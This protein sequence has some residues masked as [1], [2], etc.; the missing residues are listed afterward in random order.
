MV[1]QLI[2][3]RRKFEQADNYIFDADLDT[4][5]LTKNNKILFN[6]LFVEDSKYKLISSSPKVFAAIH[7]DDFTDNFYLSEVEM[8]AYISG[9]IESVNDNIQTALDKAIADGAEDDLNKAALD[10]ADVKLNLYRSFKS[11]YDKWI[12]SSENGQTSGYF[13]NNYGKDKDER[14]LYDH[15]KFVNRA[16]QEVGD[17]AAIDFTYLS[18]LANTKN[19]QGPT[20][21]LY[22]SLTELLG[23]NN[24]DFWPLP[25]DIDLTTQSMS[26]E[27]VKDIFRPLDFVGNIKASPMFLCVYVGGSSRT[28][29]DLNGKGNSCGDQKDDFQ[30][31]DDSFDLTD[32]T[33][34]PDEYLANEDN[35]LVIFKVRYGQ[36]AQNHFYGLQLDQAEFK[37]T[38]ES[39]QII[40]AMT[41][42][43][44]GS[45]PSQAGKGNG[46]YDVYLTRSYNCTVSSLGNMSIQPLMYFKL[47]NVPMFRGTYLITGVKHSVTP[48]NIKTEFTG[49]RQPRITVPVV[50]DA[51]SLLDLSLL[52]LESDS[53]GYSGPSTN[54]VNNGYNSDTSSDTVGAT[55]GA[56]REDMKVDKLAP[57]FDVSFKKIITNGTYAGIT[58]S[59][60]QDDW[61]SVTSNYIGRKETFTA[62]AANDEGT[63]RAGY[64][65]DKI[66]I[67]GSLQKVKA[68][69]VFTR[70]IAKNTLV[71][72]VKNTYAKQIEKDLGTSNWNKLNKFQKAALVSLGYN[73][74]AYY[75]SARKYGKQIKLAIQNNDF[76]EAAQGILNGPI[77]GA[78]SG[79]LKGLINRRI[80]EARLF[81]L[82]ANFTITYIEDK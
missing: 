76:K 2:S 22:Q 32:K 62:S 59:K 31:V 13:F 60:Y 50:T 8:D 3:L 18:N 56:T 5:T 82:D 47:E 65:T 77:S 41:N 57:G 15:F 10:D 34:W 72:Q 51:I 25:A 58:I 64:G 81:L 21:S 79:V 29:A 36:E 75:I 33:D 24:F 37:E 53:G 6:R 28:L 52:D 80:E 40:D 16:N 9:F 23:K 67:N 7:K 45:Q 44:S 71:Y 68:G 4:N 46:M 1:T 30:Y 63:L 74:G 39:L 78:Q 43:K 54:T 26:D 70:E 73:A 48:H 69:T 17:K 12:N 19:G 42:P 66:L 49:M 61:L 35:G 11:L 55:V 27:D 38:Q 14:M 20:Q